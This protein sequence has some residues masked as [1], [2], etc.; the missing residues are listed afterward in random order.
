[1]STTDVLSPTST[2]ISSD[3]IKLLKSLKYTT[4]EKIH[5]YFEQLEVPSVLQSRLVKGCP[6]I[7]AQDIPYDMVWGKSVTKV[8]G[9]TLLAL[10]GG[11]WEAN[12]Q[13]KALR[14][15]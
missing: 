3:E 10:Q 8:Y 1:M 13:E 12:C 11:G 2:A 7:G 14:N 5:L 9:S 15:T 6:I 4:S